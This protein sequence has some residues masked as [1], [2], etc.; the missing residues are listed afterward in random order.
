MN[1]V[2]ILFVLRFVVY[3]YVEWARIKHLT[4]YDYDFTFDICFNSG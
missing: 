3:S 2:N 1:L 4:Y